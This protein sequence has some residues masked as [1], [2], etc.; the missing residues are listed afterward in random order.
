MSAPK[1]PGRRAT[2]FTVGHGDRSL[3]EFLGLLRLHGIRS[4]VD[5]RRF[6]G[7]RRHP[8]FSRASLEQSL[9]EAGIAYLWEGEA[10]GGRRRPRPDSPH[11]ALRN[12]GFRGYADH[13]G[14]PL[15]RAGVERLLSAAKETPAAIMCAERLPWRCHR[16][17]IADA[18][19]AA[20][21]EVVHLIGP[22]QSREHRLHPAARLTGDGLLYDRR[23]PDQPVLDLD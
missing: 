7:S 22:G 21:A 10:L 23:E 18:L 16:Y 11:G 3:E 14:T 20:G 8:R 12:E 2:V 15:F 19:L 1:P 17:M 13:M 9:P 6:P 4:L 5:V